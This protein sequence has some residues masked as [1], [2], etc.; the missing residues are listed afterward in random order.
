[1]TKKNEI[2]LEK[3]I[4]QVESMFQPENRKTLI[5]GLT[6]C[7]DVRKYIEC[8]DRIHFFTILFIV[9]RKEVQR[10]VRKNLLFSK[11]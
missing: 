8:Y 2:N 6:F 5:D 11:M 7:K 4:K 1:M 9:N 10:P 3:A